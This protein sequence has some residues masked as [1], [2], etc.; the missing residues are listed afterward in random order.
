MKER[1]AISTDSNEKK[2]RTAGFGFVYLIISLL[3]ESDKVTFWHLCLLF[4]PNWTY[5]F[6]AS[7]CQ[8]VPG[9]FQQSKQSELSIHISQEQVVGQNF[10]LRMAQ[11]LWGLNLAPDLQVCA[12]TFTMTHPHDELFT[13]GPLEMNSGM[14][15]EGYWYTEILW[16]L[17][18]LQEKQNRH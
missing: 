1:E 2:K 5:L 16:S 15:V 10:A 7:S 13:Q 8:G 17:K 3:D 14:L 4:P 12:T 18:Q 11:H 6:P 9:L